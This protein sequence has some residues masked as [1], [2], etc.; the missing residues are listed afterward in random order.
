[1]TDLMKKLSAYG[2]DIPSVMERFVDDEALYE[3]CLYIFFDDK[4]FSELNDA[5]K[6]NSYQE[7]FD[8]A[9]TLKGVSANLGLT[10]LYD[11]I[12]HLV[13][14]LRRSEYESAQQQ[15]SSI[16]AELEKLIK[17]VS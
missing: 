3:K 17:A 15:Y 4:A 8:S 11:A 12:C 16:Y 10:P 6:S 13:E 9:H 7:A 14:S 5:I 2:V 1:M